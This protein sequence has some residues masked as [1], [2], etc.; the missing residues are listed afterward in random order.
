MNAL[1]FS[2]LSN[3]L[4]GRS[5]S[6]IFRDI[7]QRG[8]P[9]PFTIGRSAVWDE[10]AIEEWLEIR[11][12]IPYAPQQVAVPS[13]GKRRGRRSKNA[14]PAKGTKPTEQEVASAVR[15]FEELMRNAGLEPLSA[16]A[17]DGQFHEILFHH[18]DSSGRV[19]GC[20]CLDL[21]YPVVGIYRCKRLKIAKRW[22]GKKSS[23]MSDQEKKEF[24]EK[25]K[26]L[27]GVHTGNQQR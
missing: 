12:N 11:A 6:S 18:D 2:A 21:T 3:K 17:P 27:S 1:N 10:K 22:P 9:P 15:R 24:K 19:K 23:A 20:Y 8:F 13:P 5:R 7:K 26:R 25:W 14:S 4:G 16:I